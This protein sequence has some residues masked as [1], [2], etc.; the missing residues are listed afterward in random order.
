MPH[1][2]LAEINKRLDHI[3]QNYGR[4][5]L[6]GHAF[7]RISADLWSGGNKDRASSAQ[8]YAALLGFDECGRTRCMQT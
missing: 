5:L 8:V 1:K 4:T 3:K 2:D 6:T 7:R